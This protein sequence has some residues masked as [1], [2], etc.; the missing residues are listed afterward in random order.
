MR[1]RKYKKICRNRKERI[2]RRLGRRNW[3]GQ[4]KPVMSASTI[5][6]EV[7]AR[8]EA[9][10]C[11]GIGAFHQL[12][13]RIGLV[14]EINRRLH[15]LKRHLP[16]FESD[17]VL[18][19][20]YNI[21]VGGQ[22]LEDIELRRQDATFMNALGARVLPDPTTAGD[23]TRRLARPDIET[24]MDCIN[25]VR[26][27]M[28]KLSG[29][30]P[31]EEALIDVDGLLAPTDGECKQGMDISYSGVWGYHPLVTS[32]AN[33][34]EVFYLENR[35][36]NVPSHQGVVKRIDQS[37]ALVAPHAKRIC[38]RGDTAFYLTEHFD[39]WSV[40]VDFIFGMC[41]FENV[42][43]LANALPKR[44]WRPLNRKPKYQVRTHERQKPLNVK[45][46][47]VR[48]RGFKNVRL[49]SEHVAEMPYQP[50]KCKKVYRVVIVRKNLSIEKGEEVLFPD[51][52]YF[53]YI[54]TRR[55]LTAAQVVEKANGRCNQ[56]NVIEQLKNGVN[57]MRMPVN[58][59]LS[60]WAYMVMAALAWNLKA[61]FA[62]L[63]PRRERSTQLLRMEFRQF[64][65]SIIRI[66]CQIVRTGR[67]IIY[68]VL[69]YNAWLMDFFLTWEKIRRLKPA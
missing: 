21:L 47:I 22:R 61:W 45:E 8:A 3:E 26:Q 52:R 20:A 68:R 55:D 58:N 69:A 14:D 54:T 27:V 17:H 41:E 2:A 18:N 34:G 12:A 29:M 40:Q 23:F 16:Y 38:L 44:R 28:W 25:V 42:R 7:S 35:P 46:S 31:F 39:R 48:Q 53:F 24:L 49:V 56:E 1:Q 67:Q 33:T 51:I 10:G 30:A 63:V 64:L 36:G 66:P 6:Y 5:H 4:T 19:I 13:Q 43:D 50:V 32:L 11:G 15:V 57:A 65:N 62:M 9:I 60:N 37:I 59:L